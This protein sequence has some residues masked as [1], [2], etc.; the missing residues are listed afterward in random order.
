MIVRNNAL[1]SGYLFDACLCSPTSSGK[2]VN[3]WRVRHSYVCYRC[4]LN[5]HV[6]LTFIVEGNSNAEG[7]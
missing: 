2:R 4:C 6:N 3:C 1:S 5:L 7:G